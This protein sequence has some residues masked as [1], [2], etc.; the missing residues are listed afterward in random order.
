[1]ST[2]SLDSIKGMF[3]AISR[4]KN[5]IILQFP[6][7]QDLGLFSGMP[8]DNVRTF[9]ESLLCTEKRLDTSVCVRL[10][11]H[12][13]L[14]LF[15]I[16][17]LTD[18]QP[19]PFQNWGISAHRSSRSIGRL[20]EVRHSTSDVLSH[21]LSPSYPLES[22]SVSTTTTID[23]NS[24][25]H[26]DTY[27]IATTCQLD[28]ACCAQFAPSS[29]RH[30]CDIARISFALTLSNRVKLH[31]TKALQRS[32][33]S[34]TFFVAVDMEDDGL[35]LL[36]EVAVAIFQKNGHIVGRFHWIVDG[37]RAITEP[38]NRL[39]E[40]NRIGRFDYVTLTN[41][42]IV[43]YQAARNDSL[44]VVGEFHAWLNSLNAHPCVF[45]HWC[46][47]DVQRLEISDRHCI[48]VHKDYKAWLDTNNQL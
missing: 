37:V 45:L 1:M 28:S 4:A 39:K 26:E 10:F 34:D 18:S 48:D 21:S 14:P 25:Y 16:T 30:L 22:S 27:F 41:L 12:S 11:P 7:T 9:T 31:I 20:T 40:R 44:L 35:S 38:P 43:D 24:Y 46:G 32:Y 36:T 23:G 33:D 8:F 13:T 5:R 47:N 29:V 19:F 15:R 2:P 42:E 17:E 6:D 3:V